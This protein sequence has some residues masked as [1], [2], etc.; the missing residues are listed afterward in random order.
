MSKDVR[1]WM[2]GPH[3][4]RTQ[5]QRALHRGR[6]KNPAFDIALQVEEAHQRS[7]FRNSEVVTRQDTQ[8]ASAVQE[9]AEMLEHPIDAALQREAHDDVCSIGGREMRRYMREERIVAAGDEIAFAVGVS[10]D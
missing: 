7:W 6:F 9:V 3:G 8:L 5:R 4:H 1:F 10:S 2:E